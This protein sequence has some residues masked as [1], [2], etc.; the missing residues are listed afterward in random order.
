LSGVPQVPVNEKA[1]MTFAG[2]LRALLRQDPDIIL[3]GEIRDAETA[4]I[5]T[6]ASLTGHLVLSTLHTNDAATALTRLLDLD[7]AAYLVASTVDAVL[8]QRL[9]RVIC[10]HCKVETTPDRAV[11]RRIDVAGLGLTR[12]WK[13]A[14][15]DECRGTGYRGRTGVYEL[16]VMDNDLRLEVQ[17]RR[18]SEELRSMAVAKGMRTL[19]DDGVR[20]ARDGITTIDEVLRVARA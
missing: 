1:G 16:L 12:I 7:V 13:G 15:C 10:P 2:A 9:V 17:K 20:V 4:Q 3:V 5:A 6:Q 19:L 14:G 8:A 18:G 11:A